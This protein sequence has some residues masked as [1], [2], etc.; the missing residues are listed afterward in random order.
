MRFTLPS[1][2]I[3]VTLG[4]TDPATALSPFIPWRMISF[5]RANEIIL[6]PE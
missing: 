1:I 2:D 6:K 5:V 4:V 3:I